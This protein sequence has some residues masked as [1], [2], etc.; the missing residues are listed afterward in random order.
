MVASPVCREDV[1]AVRTEQAPA[2]AGLL[3]IVFDLDLAIRAHD[4][5]SDADFDVAVAII[6]DRCGLQAK[7][8]VSM[9]FA[10]MAFLSR[11]LLQ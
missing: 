9:V 4:P 3:G 8:V 7:A 6:D 1:V 2:V 5:V 10:N 11:L